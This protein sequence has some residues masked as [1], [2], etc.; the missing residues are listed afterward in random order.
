MS[1]TEFQIPKELQ[2][3]IDDAGFDPFGDVY[4]TSITKV[5]FR[6]NFTVTFNISYYGVSEW[7]VEI[8]DCEEFKIEHEGL[9]DYEFKIYDEHVLLDIYNKD[10]YSLYL[11]SKPIDRTLLI[12]DM[13]LMHNEYLGDELPF[14]RYLWG[15]MYTVCTKSYGLF[16]R[17]PQAVLQ[18][19]KEVLD[20]HGIVSSMLLEK[21]MS[22][23]YKLL[24]VGGG[25]FIAKAFSINKSS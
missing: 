1:Q 22:N 12:S 14:D 18:R 21:R 5:Q 13:Y 19:Y 16:A 17:G 25:W 6:P 3:I 4:T 2:S 20:R 23:S 7:Y 8:V 10:E 15:D 11:G 9:D 24:T